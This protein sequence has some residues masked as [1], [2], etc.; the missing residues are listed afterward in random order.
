MNLI[1]EN[2]Y[3]QNCHLEDRP[4]QGSWTSCKGLIIDINKD[5]GIAEGIGF[6]TL[7]TFTLEDAVAKYGE[8][9][10]VWLAVLGIPEAPEFS[11][12]V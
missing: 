6:K 9:T 5:N 10:T 7:S 1:Q 3:F 8:P 4:N 11:M 12:L 2:N